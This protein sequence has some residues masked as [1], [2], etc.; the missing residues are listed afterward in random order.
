MFCLRVYMCTDFQRPE[1]GVRFLGT[2]V[3]DD[4]ELPVSSGSSARA[5]N[6]LNGKAFLQ[7]FFLSFLISEVKVMKAVSP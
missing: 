6:D 2:G 1:E 5:A 4:C 7:P 3:I